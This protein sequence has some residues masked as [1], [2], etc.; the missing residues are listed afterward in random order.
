MLAQVMF[1]LRQI[2]LQALH[3]LVGIRFDGVLHLD[4]QH[5]VAAALQIQP[6]PDVVLHVL[7]QVGRAT[8]GNR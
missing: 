4:L 7:H 8:S 6:E 3:G 1:C 2:L 5:Q